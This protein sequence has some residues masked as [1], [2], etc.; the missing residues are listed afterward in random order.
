MSGNRQGFPS[1]MAQGAHRLH[2]P[3]L[4]MNRISREQIGGCILASVVPELTGL[5]EEAAR[6]VTGGEVL[7]VGPGI[8]TG[9]R[10]GIDDP[11]SG[12]KQNMLKNATTPGP[13][14]YSMPQEAAIS[15][16]KM[17]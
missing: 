11:S 7:R 2:P 6:L 17:Q 16:T 3:E 8:R 1:V 13:Q 4:R 12:S 9:F 15:C 14:S 5:V 10:I